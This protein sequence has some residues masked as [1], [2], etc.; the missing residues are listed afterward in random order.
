[1]ERREMLADGFRYLART[2]PAMVATAGSLGFLLR[3][4]IGDVVDRRA[5]CFPAQMEE[6]VQQTAIPLPK[7]D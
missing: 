5:A 1:M 2:L 4:P 6:V 7:E 3:R